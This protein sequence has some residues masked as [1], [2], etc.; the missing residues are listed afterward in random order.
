MQKEPII[1]ANAWWDSLS[2]IQW[3]AMER[4]HNIYGHDI[5]TTSDDIQAIWLAEGK[6]LPLPDDGFEVNTPESVE[7][8]MNKTSDK[9]LL[10]KHYNVV[11]LPYYSGDG[12]LTVR[13]LEKLC[14]QFQEYCHQQA[15]IKQRLIELNNKLTSENS[16]YGRP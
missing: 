7:F 8:G 14:N 11:E 13:Q 16:F 2:A 6:P 4:K 10:P 15:V 9:F 1:N 12:N 5:G 3:E